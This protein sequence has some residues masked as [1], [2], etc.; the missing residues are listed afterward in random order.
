LRNVIKTLLFG[1]R[2]PILT[3]FVVILIESGKNGAF[4]VRCDAAFRRTFASILPNGDGDCKFF[5][6]LRAIFFD[7]SLGKTFDHFCRRRENA[8]NSNVGNAAFA[9]ENFCRKSSLVSKGKSCYLFRVDAEKT[10][11]TRKNDIIVVSVASRKNPPF[12]AL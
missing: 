8:E 12:Y 10:G 6:R 7:F 11:A 4:R 5:L 2:E 9:E 1:F 3:F